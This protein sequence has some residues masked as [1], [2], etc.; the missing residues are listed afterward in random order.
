MALYVA[1]MSH[2]LTALTF[3]EKPVQPPK[4]YTGFYHISLL[5]TLMQNQIFGILMIIPLPRERH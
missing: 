2:R 5:V 4:R 1:F 3:V